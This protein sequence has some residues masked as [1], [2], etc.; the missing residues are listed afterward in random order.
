MF[1]RHQPVY[2]DGDMREAIRKVTDEPIRR[3]V[4]SH[5]HA[6]HIHGLQ[7]LKA[8]GID[9][10]AHVKA[11]QYFASGQAAERSAKP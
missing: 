6:D 2:E 10:W 8:S 5:Y 7:Q 3:I 11:K 9:I 1:G 4:V